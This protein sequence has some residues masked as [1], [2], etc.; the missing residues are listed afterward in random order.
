M[1][2]LITGSKGFIAKHLIHALSQN[3]DLEILG[4]TKD[5]EH[6]ILKK[7]LQV[8][9]VVYHLSGVNR[10]KNESD[11]QTSNIDL[12]KFICEYL[13][14]IQR[15]PVIVFSSSILVRADNAYGRSK[16][17]AETILAQYQHETDSPVIILR[18]PNIFGSGGIPHYN[19]VIATFCYSI[20]NDLPITIHS[21]NT[22]LPCAYIDDVVKDLVSYLSASNQLIYPEM[23]TPNFY[24][25]LEEIAKT[26]YGF[27]ALKSTGIFPKANLFNR[28]LYI[29]YLS[30]LPT[31]AL[32]YSLVTKSDTRGCLAELIKQT[33]FG[34][35][36]VSRTKAG[37]TRGN[38][39]HNRKIEKFIVLEGEALIRLR[40]IKNHQVTE[41]RVTGLDWQVVDIPTHMTHSITNVGEKELVTLFWANEIFDPLNSDTYALNV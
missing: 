17:Q 35:I 9:D 30:Y 23:V 6:E 28:Y 29:V 14:S 19:S 7:Y 32:C 37:V 16:Y 33:D 4:Y 18:L 36:F 40:D 34:Q 41:Y 25:S 11:F 12:T 5:Q 1:K 15:K 31:S 10:H 27:H 20:A 13:K 8:A 38:H 39:Y 2:V 21:L 3:P 26:I 22:I 24:V